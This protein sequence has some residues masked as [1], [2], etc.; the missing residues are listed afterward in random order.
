MKPI[1]NFF[2]S[3]IRILNFVLSIALLIAAFSD[4]VSPF[5]SVIFS[6]LGLF[7]P[8]IF[9]LSLVLFFVLLFTEQ[10]L[11]ACLNFLTYL[12][13]ISAIYTYIPIHRKTEQIPEDCIKLLTY[14]VMRFGK[15]GGK[16]QKESNKILRYIKES[17]ADIVCIQEFGALKNSSDTRLTEEDIMI[18]LYKYPYHNINELS[19]PHPDETFGVAIFSKYPILSVKKAPYKSKYNG[20]IICELGIK[21][22]KVTLINN[23]LESNK[24]SYE[25]RNDYYQMTQNPDSRS[26]DVFT[27]MMTKRL[28]PAY[29]LRA[30]QAQ[31]VSRMI[32]EDTNPYIIVC[33]DF[34]DTPIS[35]ARR[36]IKGNLRDAFVDSGCGLGITYNSYRF[37][38][39]IDYI[40]HSSNIKSYNCTVGK[41]RDSD[42]FPVWC[43]LELR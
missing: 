8:F 19:F 13:C 17:D 42:H 14:N 35:Y 23:H 39:R 29:R 5:R 34:N 1:K 25:E 10:W 24:L 18:A 32:A 30:I 3:I 12:A 16:S 31:T 41:L 20:S 37:L 28:T 7:F 27:R 4:F 38:F 6:Y 2:Q 15:Q 36:K 11:P 21:G 40:L 33:G 43:Y 22:R 9:L 26:L